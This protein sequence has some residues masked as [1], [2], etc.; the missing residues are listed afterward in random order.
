M[1]SP[2]TQIEILSA[3]SVLL[4]NDEITDLSSAGDWGVA[5]E[6]GYDLLLDAEVGSG[7]WR[8]AATTQQ[9]SLIGALS[10]DFAEWN[11]E[12]QLPADFVSMQR[13]YPSINYEIF[14]DKLYAGSNGTLQAEYY[15]SNPAVNLWPAPFKAYFVYLLADFLAV[16]KTENTSVINAIKEGKS[17]WA[18]HAMFT[19]SSNRPNREMQSQPYIVV[20]N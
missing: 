4:G 10:P 16:S 20:R 8:F 5:L 3:A 19:S 2:N 14:G 6:K 18:A 13:V 12:Y 9:L 1:A 11:Y 15:S 7:R 17:R